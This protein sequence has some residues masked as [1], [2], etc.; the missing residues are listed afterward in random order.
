MAERVRLAKVIPATLLLLLLWLASASPFDAWAQP[1]GAPYG[2]ATVADAP[3]TPAAPLNRFILIEPDTGVRLLDGDRLTPL[4]RIEHRR[5]LQGA[6]RFTPDGRYAFL[7][8][9]DGW[10]SKL[11]LWQLRVAAE[12]RA[13]IA[14]QGVALSG[15]GQWLLVGNR[16]PQAAVLLDADL[17]HVKTYPARTADGRHASPVAAVHDVAGRRSFVLTLQDIPELWEISYDPAAAPLFDGLVHDYKMG[18]AIARP[19]YLG[20]R[21][22]P[23]DEPL[24]DVILSPGNPAYL[25][26][27]TP[28]RAD[29]TSR[30]VVLNLD[31]RRP[32]A[33]LPMGRAPQPPDGSIFRV[34]NRP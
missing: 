16:Q 19:G 14:L 20:V 13:G 26:V 33:T 28:P 7:A 18:E 12:V 21:R 17:K 10:V 23:L 5:A 4:G 8:A 34:G 6:P 11:D 27:A 24:G 3:A 31:A 22:T 1:V 30:A 2:S 15:D 32:I 29:G 9:P 25:L